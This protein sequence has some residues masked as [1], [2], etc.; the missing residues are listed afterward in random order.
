M[1]YTSRTLRSSSGLT[2]AGT[3][4]RPASRAARSRRA[5]TTN[6][7]SLRTG[8]TRIGCRRPWVRMLAASSSRSLKRWRGFVV[9]SR[10]R[11]RGMG[12]VLGLNCCR[13]RRHLDLLSLRWGRSCA[14]SYREG[15]GVR[16]AT[17]G[18]RAAADRVR[19]TAEAVLTALCWRDLRAEPAAG[20]QHDDGRV[21]DDP[22]CRR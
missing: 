20:R 19:P 11:S 13:A 7:K 18:G 16:H 1:I 6:S 22:N 12:D 2:C 3:L 17:K 4:L 15:R 14:P 9:D 8:R 5:P 10:M 21:F